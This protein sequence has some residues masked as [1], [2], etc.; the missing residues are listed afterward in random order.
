[1]QDVNVVC[2]SGRLVRDPEL[3]ATQSGSSICNLSMAV[4]ESYKQGDEWK[5]RAH[6]FDV[7]LFGAQG[8]NAAKYLTKGSPITVQGTLQQRSWE[9]Q[10]GQKRS[11]VEVNAR[12]VIFPPRPRQE[13]NEPSGDYTGGGPAPDFGDE[14]LPF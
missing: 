10:E 2:L 7:V 9:T 5:E 8:E 6:F 4:N 12:V 11:K 13:S 3:K 14:D 1:M